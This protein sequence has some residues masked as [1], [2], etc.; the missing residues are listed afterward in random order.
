[1]EVALH[2]WGK[3]KE[4]SG[5][6]AKQATVKYGEREGVAGLSWSM[7]KWRGHGPVSLSLS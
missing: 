7:A 2:S 3:D 5:R 6:E 4:R 1:M